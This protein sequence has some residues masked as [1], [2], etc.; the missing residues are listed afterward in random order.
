MSVVEP[1]SDPVLVL[2]EDVVAMP[3]VVVVPV[4]VVDPSVGTHC[5]DTEAPEYSP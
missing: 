4:V 1:V 5:P 3:S 2:V